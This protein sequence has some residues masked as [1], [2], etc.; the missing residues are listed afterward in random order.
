M[1]LTNVFTQTSFFSFQPV[2]IYRG[3]YEWANENSP[4]GGD[5]SLWVRAATL[6]L[7]DGQ[8]QCQVTA[9]N[10]DVQVRYQSLI[11]NLCALGSTLVILSVDVPCVFSSFTVERIA[12]SDRI[13]RTYAY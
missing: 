10:Y 8:W 13:N 12:L 5:C 9:S 7:D 3:K 2:G 6:Q 4:V 1:F 11:I